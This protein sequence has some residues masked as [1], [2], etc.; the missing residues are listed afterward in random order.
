M[1]IAIYW[2]LVPEA[3]GADAVRQLVVGTLVGLWAVRLTYN[4]ARGWSGLDHEDWRYVDQRA[5]TGSFYWV[6]SFAGLHMMPTLMVFAGCL[7]L[8]PALVTG[9]E[10]FGALDV[11]A[12]SLTGGAILVGG[13]RG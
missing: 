7:A 6:V 3:S 13:D 4:W 12:T 11:A 1:P 9:R 10:A 2:V 8:W 5:N